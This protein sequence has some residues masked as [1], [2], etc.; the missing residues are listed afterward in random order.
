[1]AQ[2]CQMPGSLYHS[3][4]S[5][6]SLPAFMFFPAHPDGK[7]QQT[8]NVQPLSSSFYRS[9]DSVEL[10]KSHQIRV[11][12]YVRVRHVI[13][14]QSCR[15]DHQPCNRRMGKNL[16]SLELRSSD[17]FRGGNGVLL[18]PI[19]QR[20]VCLHQALPRPTSFLPSAGPLRDFL[21][22]TIGAVFAFLF[23]GILAR[24]WCLEERYFRDTAVERGTAVMPEMGSNPGQ[25]E[26][27]EWV[28]MVIH[29]IWKVYRRSLEVWLVQLLQPAIDN[30]GKPDYVKRV[31]IAELNL[32]C[33]PLIVRNVQ[34]RASR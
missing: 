3:S 21:F 4:S 26:S 30:L 32:D 23:A 33:E 12:S 17:V 9:N 2:T 1:M 31:Q 20:R 11:L 7:Q 6:H 34:R 10:L 18:L 15:T 13:K 27:V 25:K 14:S 16:W 24:L 29:K 5:P 22:A 8:A 28:N 19:L